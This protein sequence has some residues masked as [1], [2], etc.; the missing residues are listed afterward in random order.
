MAKGNKNNNSSND[1][2]HTTS[3]ADMKK[4]MEAMESRIV[5]LETAN[6][7]LETKVE[8]LEGRI[9]ISERVSQ[10]LSLEVDRLDQYHRRPNLII[11]GMWL[12]ENENNGDVEKKV[13]NVIK[14]ELKLPE[15]VNS[16]DKLHR[17][18]KVKEKN[19]KRMQ[20][21]I[22]RFKTHHA[23]YTVYSQRKNAKNIKIHANLTKRRGKLLYDASNAIN[24]I[25]KVNFCFSNMHGD[26]NVRLEEAYNGK[27]VHGFSSFKD[28]N[29]LLIKAGLLQQP[30]T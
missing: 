6:L 30:I 16:I 12:P 22:I 13:Q 26:L 1:N 24:G 7:Q 27:Y 9:S 3:M 2:T 11:R 10:Q 29:D 18:G 8:E 17:T 23:R 5:Q 14:D 20:D 15:M 4:K 28:L 19:G 21:V 25:D